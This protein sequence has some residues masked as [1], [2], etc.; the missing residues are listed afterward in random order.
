MRPSLLWAG[1]GLALI[2][3]LIA[4]AA[5]VQT[6]AGA[7]PSTPVQAP[8]G[9]NPTTPTGRPPVTS[10]SPAGNTTRPPAQTPPAGQDPNDHSGHNHGQDPGIGTIPA[11]PPGK[12]ECLVVDHDFGAMLSGEVASFTFEMKSVGENPLIIASAKPSCGCTVSHVKVEDANGAFVDYVYGQPI[13]SGKRV[14]IEARLDTKNKRNQ[15]SSKINVHC[16]DPRGIVTLGL[17]AMVDEFF[18]AMPA[19]LDFGDMT[20]VDAREQTAVVTAKR[21][22]KFKLRQDLPLQVPGMK[23]T[24][25]PVQPDETGAADR[26]EVKVAMGPDLREGSQGYP[27]HLASDQLVANA[28]PAI[29]GTKPS[30]GASVLVQARVRGLISFQPPYL[31]FALVRPGQTATRTIK[32]ECFDDKFTLTTPKSMKLVG[33]SDAIPEFRYA[34][35][36]DLVARPAADG[37][38]MDVDVIL[39][40][41]PETADGAFQ[42]RVLIETGHPSRP[43]VAVLFSGVCRK[44]APVPAPTPQPAPTPTPAPAT[45]GGKG[46]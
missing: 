22:G 27:V 1:L 46:N 34:E 16:N 45:G 21:G 13:P 23:V 8:V 19:T 32:I 24:L 26:W 2:T 20:T 10:G 15:A 18:A 30:Y 14:Q 28:Q 31:S 6:P 4:S 35:H 43:T 37:R 33:Q 42:G 38:S 36:F 44:M 40:G 39:K 29:D 5:F 17:T 9:Q 7:T 3:P 12:L 11:G 41:L 25:T